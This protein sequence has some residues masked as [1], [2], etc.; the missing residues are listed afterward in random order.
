MRENGISG[1]AADLLSAFFSQVADM[2][3][4]QPE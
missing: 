2:M 4:N 1:E 3:R